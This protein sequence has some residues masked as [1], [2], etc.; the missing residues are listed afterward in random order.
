MHYGASYFS[1]EGSDVEGHGVKDIYN[2]PLKYLSKYRIVALEIEM[3]EDMS[4]EQTV[5]SASSVRDAN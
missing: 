1:Y 4:S 5:N 3:L 2:P